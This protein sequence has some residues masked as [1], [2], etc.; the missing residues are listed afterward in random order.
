MR[1]RIW[2]LVQCRTVSMTET[3][4]RLNRLVATESGKLQSKLAGLAMGLLCQ[5]IQW[6]S[7]HDLVDVFASFEIFLKYRDL[8]EEAPPLCSSRRA[9]LL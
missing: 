2:I 3:N 5:K 1:K 4:T 7:K 9:M 8:F 6:H